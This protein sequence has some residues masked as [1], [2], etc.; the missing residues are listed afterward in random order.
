MYVIYLF[1]AFGG[2]YDRLYLGRGH[3]VLD[4]GQP[5]HLYHTYI[6]MYTRISVYSSKGVHVHSFIYELANFP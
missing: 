3:G 4:L 2:L 5:G 1:Q 6:C